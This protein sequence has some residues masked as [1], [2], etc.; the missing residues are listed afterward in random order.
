MA[1]EG[2]VE[3]EFEDER[4]KTTCIRNKNIDFLNRWNFCGRFPAPREAA[5]ESQKTHLRK[6]QMS[7][8]RVPLP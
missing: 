6:P 8:C 5:K 2:P 7:R 4:A 3:A 1:I